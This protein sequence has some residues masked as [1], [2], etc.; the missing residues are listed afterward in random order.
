VRHFT[1]S[2]I[3]SFVLLWAVP[4]ASAQQNDQG[5]GS[6]PGTGGNNKT[7]PK[8]PSFSAPIP[9]TPRQLP[10]IQRI[11]EV[12][13][14]SGSVIQED[15]GPA[16]FGTTIELD[17]GDSIT[18]EATVDS[19]GHYGFQV[20]SSNR[21]GRVMADASDQIGQD[22][23]DV[24][25]SNRNPLVDTMPSMSRTPLS[26]KLLQCELR[27][28]YPGYRSTSVRMKPGEIF[29]FTAVDDILMY[30]IDKV[31]GTSVS[32]TSL[33]APKEAKKSMERARKAITKNK[34]HEAETQLKSSIQI[35]PQNAEAL[36]LLGQV[37]LLQQR[38]T[39]ARKS[40]EKA[41]EVDG[42][43]VRPYLSLAR[44]SLVGK[45]WKTAA[46]LT[47]KALDLDPISFPQA[48]MLNALAY[49]YLEDMAAAEKGARK[50]LRLDLSNRYPQM[51]LLLANI[52]SKR[53]DVPGSL[54]EMHR[55]LKA[56]PNAAD[57]P[58]VRSR[59][60][61]TEKLLKAA[62]D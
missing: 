36:F 37:Y 41:I 38:D 13:F 47:D 62:N 16:P 1:F 24:T 12:V 23:F 5:N 2:L 59:I 53:Q 43:Y 28:E 33:L 40:F 29:G 32:A 44:I 19:Q 61:E 21:I 55:Y 7:P 51:H 14:I 6:T 11:P 39:E 10:E 4:C 18:R 56:A 17:C 57:A 34:F 25:A 45:D 46:G 49:Y 48:Y 8:L 27:A 54:E 50:G 31:Q 22:P 9:E 26:I 3:L 30:R 52:L 60:Q 58:L 42:F 35:Y 20:G 15:G